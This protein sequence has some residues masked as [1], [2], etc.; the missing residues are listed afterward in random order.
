MPE[1][2][3]ASSRLEE[4]TYYLV[5]NSQIANREDR[6][7]WSN[8]ARQRERARTER[9]RKPETEAEPKKQLRECLG[10]R[11]LRSNISGQCQGRNYKNE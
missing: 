1:G 3:R 11:R 5:R 4:A 9:R 10:R 7:A 6:V 8:W 2:A